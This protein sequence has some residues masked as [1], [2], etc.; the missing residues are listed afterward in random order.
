ML[1][2]EIERAAATVADLTTKHVF[3]FQYGS[4]VFWNLDEAE[5]QFFLRFIEDFEEDAVGP[6]EQ[7]R[8][9]M[10]FI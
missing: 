3:F 4:V 10:T 7:E 9:D 5:Q 2:A 1:E 6:E 8:D